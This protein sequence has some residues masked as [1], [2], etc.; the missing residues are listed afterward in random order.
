M[1]VITTYLA[2]HEAR[3]LERAMPLFSP[4][5]VVIDEGRAHHGREAIRG[6]L[7]GAAS[8]FTWTTT[9]VSLVALDEARYDALNHLE[10]DFPG[11]VVDL[12]F[13]FTLADGLIKRLVI[14][15]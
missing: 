5:A 12:H 7:A 6:W 13:R 1:D 10:G 2:A 8:E 4:D 15:P 3:D 14:E 11:G 9:L